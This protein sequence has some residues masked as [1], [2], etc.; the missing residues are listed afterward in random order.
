[1]KCYY[2]KD[3]DAIGFCDN[4]GKGICSECSAEVKGK[5][6]CYK[7]MKDILQQKKAVTT[8]VPAQTTEKVKK[9]RPAFLGLIGVLMILGGLLEIL[10]TIL[11][12]V[13][14]MVQ[15][16]YNPSM[17]GMSGFLNLQLGLFII[18]GLV[19]MIAGKKLRNLERGGFYLTFLLGL[20]T[21]LAAPF[22]MPSMPG[23]I[24]AFYILELLFF[25][26]TMLYLIKIR[27]VFF[28]GKSEK[29]S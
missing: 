18:Y 29:K 5:T 15:I 21:I 9:K 23:P 28:G 6:Y 22:L 24:A 13:A 10:V 11:A 7:C 26:I 20:L 8:P 25:A 19:I 17:L 14:L 27:K 12:Y 1:M 2:H 16:F 3:R 4:C